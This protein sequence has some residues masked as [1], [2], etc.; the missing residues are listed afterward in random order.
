MNDQAIKSQ[1]GRL[2]AFVLT[3]IL[4]PLSAAVA[5]WM[6]DV[7]GLNLNGADLTA[8][9]ISVVV[10][11]ALAIYKWL[12]NRGEWE[13]VMTWLTQSHLL[14]D[15]PPPVPPETVSSRKRPLL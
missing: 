13:R 2:V 3:P 10:G 6:Q 4:L 7:L 8:F 12:S 9:V 15:T 5:N 1:I 11:V 14:G